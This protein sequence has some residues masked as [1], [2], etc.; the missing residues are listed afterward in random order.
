MV[1]G[2]LYKSAI[3]SVMNPVLWGA[4]GLIG[5]IG[6]IILFMI[7]RSFYPVCQ[8]CRKRQKHGGYCRHCGSILD[9]SCSSCGEKVSVHDIFYRH[10]GEHL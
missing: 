7:A 6:T 10:C 2:W 5:N 9:R 4:L 1:A 8:N 3:Y